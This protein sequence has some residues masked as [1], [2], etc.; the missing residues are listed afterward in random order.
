MQQSDRTRAA[1]EGHCLEREGHADGVEPK[2]LDPVQD[3]AK[4]LGQSGRSL[5]QSCHL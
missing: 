3:D 1:D 5:P 2:Q 4:V